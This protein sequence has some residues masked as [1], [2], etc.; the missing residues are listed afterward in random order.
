MVGQ[1]TPEFW[2]VTIL[3]I[4]NNSK[5]HEKFNYIATIIQEINGYKLSESGQDNS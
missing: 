5:C 1:R 3:D 4:N 2:G